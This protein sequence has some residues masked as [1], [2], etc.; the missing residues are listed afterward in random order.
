MST[1][2]EIQALV[3]QSM[4]A[5]NRH[6]PAAF[7]ATFSEDA[8]FTNWQGF[9]AQGRTAIERLHAPLFAG[10]FRESHM[11]ADEVRVRM[12]R[13]DLASVDVRSRQTGARDNGDQPRPER[14]ALLTCIVERESAG[15]R[16]KVWHTL[17]LSN[18]PSNVRYAPPPSP[19][20]LA[21]EPY[22]SQPTPIPEP[23]SASV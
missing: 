15:W 16:F 5:W 4:A 7:S 23:L 3:G 14:H 17:D 21:G 1:E 13:E 22:L 9:G 10:R 20:I 19:L 11:V 2:E 6:D 18:I 12:L 8:D